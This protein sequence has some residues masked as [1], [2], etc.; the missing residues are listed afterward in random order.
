VCGAILTLP[1]LVNVWLLWDSRWSAFRQMFQAQLVSLVFITAA[2][3]LRH[4]DLDWTRPAAVIF[5]CGMVF[6]LLAYAAFYTW[7]EVGM[8]RAA[9]VAPGGPRG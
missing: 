9:P 4:D 1:G 5:V 2:L 3:A 8:R 7:G 6:S